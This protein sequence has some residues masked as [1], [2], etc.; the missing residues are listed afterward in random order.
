MKRLPKGMGS[1]YKLSG[2]R[3]RPYTARIQAGRDENGKPIYKYLGYYETAQEAIQ[4]LTDY[5]KSPYD[6]DYNNITIAG[7][8]EIFKKR[9]F[10]E[11]S[12][13]AHYIYKAAYKHLTPLH[14]TPIKDIKT[15][16][17]QKIVDE[18][19]RC[20]QTKSHIQTLLNQLFDIAIE[21]DIINKNYSKFFKLGDKADSTLH[22]AFTDDEIKTLFKSVFVED[23]ADTVLIMIY[24]GMRPS[25]M[26]SIRTENIHLQERYFV[27]GLKTKAGKNRVIPIAEKIYPLV[28]KRYNPDNEF[29]IKMSYQTY[30]D[31]FYSM[32]ARLNMK[33]LPDDGR[34]TCSS[35]LNSAGVNLTTIKF[36]LGHSSKDLTERVYTHKTVT[37]LLKAVNSI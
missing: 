34:H 5:N 6:L 14:N 12:P 31:R 7:M 29:F 26:L 19:D 2:N 32:M 28:L 35:L 15:Y 21:L 27:G 37:E 4:A 20:W 24:T 30:K 11:L 1:V 36:I 9:R 17:L 22:T 25:E 18:V 33:H 16:Q 13:S 8:W 3:R 23:L 10:N